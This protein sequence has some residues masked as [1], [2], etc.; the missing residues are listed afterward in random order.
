MQSSWISLFEEEE[1]PVMIADALGNRF[2]SVVKV[3]MKTTYV[4]G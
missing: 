2:L 1:S 4:A 3:A